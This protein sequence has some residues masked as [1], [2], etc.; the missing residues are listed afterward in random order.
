[1]S[2]CK[3]SCNRSKLFQSKMFRYRTVV[4]HVSQTV[5]LEGKRP[6]NRNAFVGL[7][8]NPSC[9][10]TSFWVSQAFVFIKCQCKS[11]QM[12]A[13]GANQGSRSTRVVN[14]NILVTNGKH[15]VLF[16]VVVGFVSKPKMLCNTQKNQKKLEHWKACRLDL[17][18]FWICCFRFSNPFHHQILIIQ[19]HFLE[20]FSIHTMESLGFSVIQINNVFCSVFFGK[21]FQ[22]DKVLNG[23]TRTQEACLLFSYADVKNTNNSDMRGWIQRFETSTNL[24]QFVSFH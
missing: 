4:Q 19:H 13:H 11:W 12:L 1:M 6:V 8:V 2:Q 3:L 7:S 17:F 10:V 5:N 14:K 24:T 22:R 9:T 15:F 18:F 23:I 16:S 21:V 20:P